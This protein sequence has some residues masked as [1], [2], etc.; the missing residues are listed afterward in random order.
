LS[1]NVTALAAWPLTLP[2]CPILNGFAE[3]KQINVVAFSPDV[4]PPKVRRRSTAAAWNTSVA[5]RMT[6]T[7]LTAFNAFYETSL[8][9]GSLAF[10]WRHPIKQVIYNWMFDPKEAPRVDHI[11]ATTWRVTFNLLR[12]P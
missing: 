7:Q 9:D 5:Y 4:G 6:T 8:A 11:T 3:Q 2:Q 12:L 1:A 10:T